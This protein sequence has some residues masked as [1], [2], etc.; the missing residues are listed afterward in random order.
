MTQDSCPLVKGKD[1]NQSVKDR[2]ELGTVRGVWYFV[3]NESLLRK[4]VGPEV[5]KERSM[6]LSNSHTTPTS[7]YLNEMFVRDLHRR[8]ESVLL[9]KYKE[10]F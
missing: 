3:R 1:L 7:L 2:T 10:D 6:Y 5:P 9:Q 8:Y 4:I